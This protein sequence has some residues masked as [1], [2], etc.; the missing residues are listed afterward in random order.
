[1]IKHTINN[2]EKLLAAYDKKNHL[3]NVHPQENEKYTRYKKKKGK[4]ISQIKVFFFFFCF[5]VVSKF[6][7]ISICSQ[8]EN[9]LKK[10][11]GK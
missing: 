10:R 5:S 6:Y 4:L 11:C 2:M 8:K 7:T 1:M 3:K 9:Y